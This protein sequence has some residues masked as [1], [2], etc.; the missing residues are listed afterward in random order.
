[1]GDPAK[2]AK[3]LGW[4]P[5]ITFAALVKEMVAADIKMLATSHESSY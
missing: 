5:K 1:M 2:A 4:K 3:D